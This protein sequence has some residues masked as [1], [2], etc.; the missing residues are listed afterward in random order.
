MFDTGIEAGISL[1]HFFFDADL[2]YKSYIW[3]AALQKLYLDKNI[4]IYKHIIHT[5]VQG[6]IMIFYLQK[7]TVRKSLLI[8]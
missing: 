5:I 6:V 4:I 2:Q 1:N 8:L 7:G 3:L